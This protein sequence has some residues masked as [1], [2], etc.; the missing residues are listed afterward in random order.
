V[1]ED[2]FY[3]DGQVVHSIEASLWYLLRAGNYRQVVLTAER[4]YHNE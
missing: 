2:E 3:G 4:E 1:S